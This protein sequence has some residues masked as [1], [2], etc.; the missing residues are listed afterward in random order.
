MHFIT[1]LH[2]F[3]IA[4]PLGPKQEETSYGHAHIIQKEQQSII[5]ALSWQST[6]FWAFIIK[7]TKSISVEQSTSPL[8][9]PV[10]ISLEQYPAL[11]DIG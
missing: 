7:Q 6:T 5:T 3:H 1:C 11:W 8:N 4:L 9:L 10:G 2:I